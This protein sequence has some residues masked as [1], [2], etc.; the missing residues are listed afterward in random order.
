MAARDIPETLFD[1]GHMRRYID[2]RPEIGDTLT[3]RPLIQRLRETCPDDE[4]VIR[5][6]PHGLLSDLNVHTADRCCVVCGDTSYIPVAGTPYSRCCSCGLWYQHPIPTLRYENP[7]HENRGHLMNDHDKDVNRGLAQQLYDTYHPRSVFDIGSKY[8]YLLHC[9]KKIGVE[10]VQGIDG[11]EKAIEYG[12]QL[13]V[14]MLKA[15]FLHCYPGRTFDL[16]T[17]VH[18][19]EHFEDPRLAI[20]KAKSALKKD[21]NLFLRTPCTDGDVSRDMT[22]GHFSIHPVLF[23]RSSLQ[24]LLEQEGFEILDIWEAADVGQID[25]HAVYRDDR[26]SDPILR[27]WTHKH[28]RGDYLRRSRHFYQ[29]PFSMAHEIGWLPDETYESPDLPPLRDVSKFELPSS[30]IVIVHETG[31]AA[32]QWGNDR[33]I[34]VVEWARSHEL[35]VVVLGKSPLGAKG[36]VDLSGK[37]SV[38]ESM[39]IIRDADLVVSSDTVAA[40]IGSLLSIPTIA[41]MGPADAVLTHLRG[42]FPIYRND[43]GCTKCYNAVAGE[44]PYDEGHQLPIHAS[45]GNRNCMQGITVRQ[46]LGAIAATFDHP[47]GDKGLLSLCMMVKNEETNVG[48]ALQS[49]TNIADEFIVVDTGSTD[50]TKDVVKRVLE[51]RNY[52]IVDYDPGT[53]I[54]SFSEVRNVAFEYA[55]GRYVMWLDA[56]DRVTDDVALRKVVEKQEFDSYSLRTLY[57]GLAYWRERIVLRCFAEFVDDVHE[58]MRID[59]LSSTQIVDVTVEHHWTEKKGRETSLKRNVRLLRQMIEREGPDHPRYPRWVY[60]LARDMMQ[61]GLAEQA[62]SY[63]EERAR[64]N[65]FWEERALAAISVARIHMMAKRYVQ[66]IQAAYEAMKMCDGWRDP[67]YIVGDAYFWLG[68]YPTAIRWFEHC[69]KIPRPS[70]S[71]GVNAA[72]YSWLPYCQLSY[73][74]ERSGNKSEALRWLMEERKVAPA[75]QLDRINERVKILS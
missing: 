49:A 3:L 12:K 7:V 69:L 68:N 48:A 53:P 70:T 5:H 66:A 58:T 41:L 10:T 73:S 30:Y 42:V 19:I 55:T 37:T 44:K 28:P 63:F 18:L 61:D 67:Y 17:M 14:P 6:D 25:I 46:V 51:G 8:P 64:L 71:L 52:Q 74:H 59:G 33:W 21:G 57:G 45:C 9:M 72:L 40:H 34:R 20:R 50:R 54:R 75:G 32:R 22:P 29:F 26:R 15:N 36:A 38:I 65:G 60:Y 43:G 24:M 13:G 35:N 62:L 1:G 27:Q 4:I 23:N 31:G 47:I 39:S 2:N 11:C 56:G 16:L